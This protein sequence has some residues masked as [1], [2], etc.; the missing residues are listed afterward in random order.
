MIEEAE[1]EGFLKPGDYVIEPTSGN[2]GIGLALTCA[3]KGYK[4]IIVM[5]EKMSKEKNDVLKAFGATIIR[6]PTS[7]AFDAPNSHISEAQRIKERLNAEKPGCAHILDQY[8]NAYNPI[9]HYDGTAQEILDQLANKIDLL[10]VTAGTGGTICGLARKIKEK[11]PKCII[12]GVDPVGSILAEPNSLNE[13]TGS[14]FYEVEGIGYDFVPTVLDRKH[15]DA[16]Y[17]SVDKPSFNL[18][19]QL[20]RRE[21]FLC[22]GSSGSATYCALEAIKKYNIKAGQNVVVLMP[23]SIR[24]YMLI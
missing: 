16:W 10:V 19:R 1:R 2:T 11:C 21:G 5:P 8:T 18:A 24:N 15:V 3:V 7:A 13:F 20:M 17:K 6:T 12:V 22:G 4:C 14:G 9:T 23:D